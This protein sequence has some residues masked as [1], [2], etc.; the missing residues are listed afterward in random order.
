[1]NKRGGFSGKNNNKHSVGIH[2]CKNSGPH[3]G[4]SGNNNNNSKKHTVG[5]HRCSDQ[6]SR[7]VGPTKETKRRS[8]RNRAKA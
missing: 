7:S 4:V 6:G 5:I 1:M 8:L 2:R 3:G